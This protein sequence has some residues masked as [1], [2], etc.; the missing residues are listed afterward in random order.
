MV[1]SL[2]FD[3][4]ERVLQVMDE[5]DDAVAGVRQWWLGAH[6]QILFLLL[7]AGVLGGLI[8]ALLLGAAPILLG[9]AAIALGVH[10][11]ISLHRRVYRRAQHA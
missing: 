3:P 4:M 11:A 9:A 10:G 2:F 5:L 7:C 8:A 6:P 1:K